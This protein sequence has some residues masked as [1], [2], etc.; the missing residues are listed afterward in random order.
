M[1]EARDLWH[2]VRDQSYELGLKVESMRAQAASLAQGQERGR[3]LI[4]QLEQRVAEFEGELSGLGSEACRWAARRRWSPTSP[5]SR[6]LLQ[7]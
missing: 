1:E 5:G 3:E 2:E 4:T 7:I 6:R